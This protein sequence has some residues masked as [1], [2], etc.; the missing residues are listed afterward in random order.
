M[1]PNH[2]VAAVTA[3]ATILIGLASLN[4]HHSEPSQ[5]SALGKLRSVCRNSK[6][7]NGLHAPPY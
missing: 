7:P 5:E 1:C 4:S 2:F 6:S 3:L